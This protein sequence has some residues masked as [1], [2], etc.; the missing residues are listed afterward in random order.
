MRYLRPLLLC[1][2][3]VVLAAP[4]FGARRGAG[5]AVAVWDL[6]V[7][8]DN[9]SEASHWYA[10]FAD[11]LQEVPELRADS[12]RVFRPSVRPA[13]G[14]TVA[15]ENAQRWLE[16]AWV[17]Y[18]G[19][20]LE[21]AAALVAD[22]LRLVEPYP[23]ARL[24]EGLA[25]DLHLLRGRVLLQLGRAETAEA[26]LK[27]AMILDPSWIAEPRW[28][29][30]DF[31]LAWGRLADERERTP[32][33]MV[34]VDVVEEGASVLVYGVPQGIVG[35]DGRLDLYLPAGLYEIT[36]RKA[37]FADR[38]ERVHLRPGQDEDLDL[39]ISVRNSAG[40]QEALAAALAAPADQKDSGVWP[41]LERASE[42]VN[43]RAILVGRFD[44]DTRMLQIGLFLPGRE[45]WGWYAEMPITRERSFDERRAD[46]LSAEM[47]ERMQDALWL[48]AF[49]GR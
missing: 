19:G 11:A 27:A 18:R 33:G 26:A 48:N 17:A 13:A 14:L 47:A 42:S 3:L 24:P 40:F 38:T 32:K 4:A 7:D 1:S 9:R 21:P 12:G 8:D 23:A 16:A 46:L 39:A 20:E 34:H 22:A 30:T 44:A 36:G 35:A 41:G 2:L 31:L 10:R 25:R 45:G 43:A 6:H 15:S 29:S 28:E 5:P 49:A 37:G